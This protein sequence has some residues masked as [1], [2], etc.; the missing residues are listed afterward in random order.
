MKQLIG[1]IFKL[2]TF[3]IYIGVNSSNFREYNETSKKTSPWVTI[4]FHYNADTRFAFIMVHVCIT[5]KWIKYLINLNTKKRFYF[6]PNFHIF[7]HIIKEKN[8]Q[9]QLMYIN[10]QEKGLIAHTYTCMRILLSFLKYNRQWKICFT[11]FYVYTYVWQLV[12]S[13]HL[14]YTYLLKGII[15]QREQCEYQGSIG[16]WF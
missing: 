11:N 7:I 13:Y 2:I 4:Q 14:Y 1:N 12:D 9:A 10:I 3:Q 5:L 8:S 15:L 6:L 16:K